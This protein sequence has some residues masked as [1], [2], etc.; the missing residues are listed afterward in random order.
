[1]TFNIEIRY[2]DIYFKLSLRSFIFACVEMYEILWKLKN[3]F[4]FFSRL[5]GFKIHPLAYQI[6]QQSA[7]TFKA[8]LRALNYNNGKR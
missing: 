4:Y 8:P 5:Y 3:E 1:M 6:Q 2:W 7:S